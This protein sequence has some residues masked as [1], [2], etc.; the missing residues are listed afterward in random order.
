MLP[1]DGNVWW[2]SCLANC[3]NQEVGEIKFKDI[4]YKQNLDGFSLVNH[5]RFAKLSYPLVCIYSLTVG[6]Y[7][8]ILCYR[9]LC[10][11]W[12]TDCQQRMLVVYC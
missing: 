3:Q 12:S 5:G 9:S 6:D 11:V 4:N 10:C 7:W 1:Y 8:S 2:S